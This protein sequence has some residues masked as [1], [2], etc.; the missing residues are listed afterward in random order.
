MAGYQDSC[1]HEVEGFKREVKGL[2]VRL[3]EVLEEQFKEDV[4]VT[5]SGVFKYYRSF[6]RQT[7]T[8]CFQPFTSS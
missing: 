5:Q 2:V 1:P 3:M 6:M 8:S 7:P 4:K